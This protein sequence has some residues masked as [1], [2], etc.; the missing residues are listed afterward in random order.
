MLRRAPVGVGG[1]PDALVQRHGR[2]VE[3]VRAAVALKM[4]VLLLLML[5]LL[6]LLVL[7]YVLLVEVELLLVGVHVEVRRKW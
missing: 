6:M 5:L 3:V 1:D 2:D 7:L 4:V